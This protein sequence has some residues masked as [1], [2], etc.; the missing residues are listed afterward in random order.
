MLNRKVMIVILTAGW[1]KKYK[2][3]NIFWNQNLQEK[4]K[5]ELDLSNYTTKT[6][7]TGIDTSSFAKG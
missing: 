7:A 4:G 6:D 3:V 2:G 1:V 5:V